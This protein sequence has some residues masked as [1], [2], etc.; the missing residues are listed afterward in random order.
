VARNSRRSPQAVAAE[1]WERLGRDCGLAGLTVKVE[2][3]ALL[4]ST[5][6]AE[7]PLYSLVWEAPLGVSGSRE[8]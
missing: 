4:E 1:D 6:R 8:D 5:L 2:N 7:G 3:V